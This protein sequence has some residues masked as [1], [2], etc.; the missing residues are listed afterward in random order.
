MKH[1]PIFNLTPLNLRIDGKKPLMNSLACY[2]AA[3]PGGWLVFLMAGG[4]AVAFCPDPDH[5]WDGGTLGSS[6]LPFP[7]PAGSPLEEISA[8]TETEA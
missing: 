3:V 8:H 4:V 7:L 6:G 5:E 2:R 1:G